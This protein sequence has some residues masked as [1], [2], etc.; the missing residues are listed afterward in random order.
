M[1]STRAATAINYKATS[2]AQIAKLLKTD[3]YTNN[4]KFYQILIHEAVEHLQG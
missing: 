4:K 2:L 1:S 3:F